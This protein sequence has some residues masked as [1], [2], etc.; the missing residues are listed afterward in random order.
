M[1][2]Q[3]Q[4]TAPSFTASYNKKCGEAAY[5]P[6]VD[7]DKDGD[8]DSGDQSFYAAHTTDQAWCQ[9]KLSETTSPCPIINWCHT[10]T[11]YLTTGS[12][13]VTSNG[14]VLYLQ[15]ALAKQGFGVGADSTGVFGYGTAAAVVKFQKE[16][17]IT[18]TGTVGPVTRAKLNALY[19][20]SPTC[21]PNWQCSVWSACA[22][23]LQTRTCPD[24]NNC[25]VT[26]GKPA[27]SQ[28]CTTTYC[29]Q[30]YS[31][32]I[33]SNA[34]SYGVA[35]YDPAAD[36]NKD[37]IVNSEDMSLYSAN[38]T[39]EQW[40]L[41]KLGAKC[42]PNWQ[43]S[44]WSACTNG[45]QTST[46][47]DSNN[48][49]ITTNKPATTRS[50][51]ST[52]TPNW[53]CTVWG[54]CT[55]G[56]QTKTCPD[57]NNCGVTTGKPAESQ[58]CI[59][60]CTPNWQCSVWS[61]CANSLQTRTCPDT[62]NCGV[63][64]GKPTESQACTAQPSI[65]VT[66]PNGGQTWQQGET[67]SITWTS[68]GVSNVIIQLYKGAYYMVSNL[69]YSVPASAGSFS[70]TIPTTLTP[71]SDYKVKIWDTPNY[72]IVDSSDNYFTIS[73]ISTCTPNW[74]CSGWSSCINGQQTRACT[75]SNNCG[76]TAGKPF[77]SQTCTP[78]S[79]IALTSP[80]GGQT[81]QQGE[82][83]SITWTSTGV[84]NVII[85]LYKGSYIVSNL[86]YSV[87]ASAGSFSWA[88]PTTITPG[89][90][91]KVKIWD[92]TNSSITDL[93]DNYFTIAQACVPNWQCSGWSAC[94]SGQQTKTC[95]DSNN[96]GT[97]ANKPSETQT[98]TTNQPSITVTSPNGGQTWQMGQTYTISWS[99]VGMSAQDT[100]NV[101]LYSASSGNTGGYMIA[102][103]TP[104]NNGLYVWN[105]PST[106]IG[107][108]RPD[109]KF[110]IGV[111]STADPTNEDISDNYFTIAAAGDYCFQ[112]YS[113]IDASYHKDCGET[114]YDPVADIDKNGRVSSGDET[115]YDAH[116]TDQTWCQQRLSET[117]SPCTTAYQSQLD[118]ISNS[119]ASIYQQL[120]YLL[121]Q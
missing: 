108:L 37:R 16:Y 30:L 102:N 94:V 14:E 31:K 41:Q 20:C 65:T 13:D 109:N 106:I 55:N 52:C 97:T 54:M 76:T 80:N 120:K 39:N 103:I 57:T 28:A 113:K 107:V 63:T 88:V 91:Y 110:I 111:A 114:G 43:C 90:D 47:T 44:A 15:T 81:W 32:L 3:Q 4:L 61:A 64:A 115:L 112:L 56:Q 60:T 12:T 8:V 89:S 42:T 85:Q 21:V 34:K 93:S 83:H 98:C 105:I 24:T 119:V 35:G 36:I 121:G 18:Q 86:T 19:G 95:T 82:T 71:G 23:S 78:Q 10:F 58:A 69:A 46:C 17:N 62:N 9:Q 84:S 11:R 49:G 77:E 2:Q 101:M 48:C 70:W 67:H 22:N 27:E 75:D 29:S 26:T 51:S 68:T 33:A 5:D 25:G 96:C 66:S 53:N 99:A 59:A 45:Q 117:T 73:S 74:Q 116:K 87:P 100:V 92:T 38:M 40:C 72:S 118:F 1:N 79:S 6:L 50:C 7:V 104:A